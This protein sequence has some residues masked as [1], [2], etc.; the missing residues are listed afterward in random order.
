MST[1]T[2]EQYLLEWFLCEQP[3]G[4]H[5]NRCLASPRVLP[6]FSLTEAVVH[7]E[8]VLNVFAV[9]AC[10]HGKRLTW[11]SWEPGTLAQ[12]RDTLAFLATLP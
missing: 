11:K 4:G 2:I 10:G 1:V 8:E 12:L 5:W 6:Q 9:V 7:H 3:A